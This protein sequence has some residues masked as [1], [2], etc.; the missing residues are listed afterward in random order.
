MNGEVVQRQITSTLTDRSSSRTFF[1]R[2]ALLLSLPQS[3]HRD[4][5]CLPPPQ[6]TRRNQEMPK[7]QDARTQ[8]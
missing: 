6:F 7:F 8:F 2:L 4:R 1:L 3:I 5:P